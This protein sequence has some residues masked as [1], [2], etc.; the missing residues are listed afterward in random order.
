MAQTFARWFVKAS[1]LQHFGVMILVLVFVYACVHFTDWVPSTLLVV[2][3][4]AWLAYVGAILLVRRADT[5][6]GAP[7]HSG[8]REL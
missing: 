7:P 6:N 2:V 4:F 5:T 1:A 3:P 8:G